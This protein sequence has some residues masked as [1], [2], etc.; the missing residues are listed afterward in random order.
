MAIWGADDGVRIALVYRGPVLPIEFFV[1]I[2]G[3]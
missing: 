2:R 3:N 1:D